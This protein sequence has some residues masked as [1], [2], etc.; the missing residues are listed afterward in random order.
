MTRKKLL[1]IPLMV[2]AFASL[3]ALACSALSGGGGA[4]PEP[5]EVPALFKDDF[6]S[7]SSGWSTFTSDNASV[8][9][10][11]GNYVMKVFTDKWFV[12]GNPSESF[13]NAHIEVTA[14]NTGGATDT[15]FGI[16]CSYQD[17]THYYYVGIDT[18]GFYA[19]A[20]TIPGQDDFF[21]TNDNKWDTSDAITKDAASYNIGADCGGGT[22]T[23]YVD[24]KQIASATDSDYGAGDVGLFAWTDQQANG[25]IHFDDL[26]VTALP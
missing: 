10:A 15:S 21:L 22:L 8:D 19:I 1:S 18:Q 9:Y 16:I 7:S 23:L 6:S 4:T 26:V 25:E 13:D 17:E 3:A 2:L 12:W 14:R 5:T 24:G 20:K 11:D